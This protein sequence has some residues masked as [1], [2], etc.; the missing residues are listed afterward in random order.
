MSLNF[1]FFSTKNIPQYAPSDAVDICESSAISPMAFLPGILSIKSCEFLSDVDEFEKSGLTK[2]KSKLIKPCG[3]SESPVIFE[4]KLI[5]I[6]ELGGKPG[7][8]NLILGE[9]CHFCIKLPRHV[10]HD[11]SLIHNMAL[12]MLKFRKMWDPKIKNFT[13]FLRG[14]QIFAGSF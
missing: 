3:V 5:D 8:G 6:I 7:S 13:I 11:I 12:K 1:L 2:E 10:S 9:I 14:E 4:C